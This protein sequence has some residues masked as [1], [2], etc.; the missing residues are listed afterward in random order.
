MSWTKQHKLLIIYSCCFDKHFFV[1]M[2]GCNNKCMQLLHI[3]MHA[4]LCELCS[5]DRGV[6]GDIRTIIQ[7]CTCGSSYKYSPHR[8]QTLTSAS[9]ALQESLD[10]TPVS[11]RT[12]PKSSVSSAVCVPCLLSPLSPLCS[13]L[14]LPFFSSSRS[15]IY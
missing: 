1:D 5:T 4:Q 10:R 2:H 14:L 9:T 8:G 15:D 13:L 7:C 6:S 3:V 12:A 11:N